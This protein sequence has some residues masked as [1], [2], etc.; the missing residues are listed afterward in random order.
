MQ[1]ER[2]YFWDRM[3]IWSV[4]VVLLLHAGMTYMVGVPAWWYVIDR[5]KSLFFLYLVLL[6]DIFPMSMLFFIAGHFAPP[7]LLKHGARDFIVGKIRRIA[8]PWVVGVLVV[9]PFF[10]AGS[11]HALGYPIGDPLTFFTGVFFGSAYQQGHY[12]FLGVLLAFFLVFLPLAPLWREQD[13][14]P[15]PINWLLVLACWIGSVALYCAVGS[16]YP[17]IDAWFNIGF[18]LYFQQLR[19]G[20]YLLIF[21]LGA[22]SWKKRWFEPRPSGSL[23]LAALSFALLLLVATIIL[24]L[25]L[26]DEMRGSSLWMYAAAHQGAALLTVLASTL[27]LRRWGNGEG[28]LVKT[29]ARASF[30][31]Y[32]IHMPLLMLFAYLLLPFNW[33]SALKFTLIV[34]LTLQLGERG[35]L[36][37][38]KRME[39]ARDAKK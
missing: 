24:R 36:M 28:F 9:A 21:L 25:K 7:S 38:L 3:R 8:L 17:N 4:Y 20:G 13:A 23:A 31:L 15:T 5:N 27:C 18:V 22:Y 11:V 39:G 6:L 10:A 34:L 2:F 29:A 30:G 37:Y 19:V 14:K 32:W 35:T 12:W 16:V 1:E 26:G 33:P